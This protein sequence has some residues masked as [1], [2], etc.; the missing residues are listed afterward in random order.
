MGERPD[1][2]QVSEVL[3]GL[4]A[5]LKV[6]RRPRRR[7][8]EERTGLSAGL[9]ALLMQ[10]EHA[11]PREHDDRGD[12]SGS[13]SGAGS[14]ISAR[15]PASTPRRS[16]ARPRTSSPSGSFAAALHRFA[17]GLAEVSAAPISLPAPAAPGRSETT[18]LLQATR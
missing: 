12:E 4:S 15:S 1:R 14:R 8:S 18:H 6:S 9:M 5:L 17:R 7:W 16:A 10:I 2:E 3:D 11:S 13:V